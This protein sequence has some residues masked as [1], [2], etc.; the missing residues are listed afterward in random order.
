MGNPVLD[1]LERDEAYG[2]VQVLAEKPSGVTELVVP[3]GGGPLYVRKRIP[4]AIA[5]IEAWVRLSS[6][7]HPHLPHVIEMYQLPDQFVVVCAYVEG[8]SAARLVTSQGALETSQAL[9]IIKDVC[10]AAGVLHA[11]GI[12]HRDIT[13]TNV[14]VANDGAHLIDLGIARVED[15]S[16][17]HDTTRLGTWGFAAPEQFGFA[18]TDARSDVY[19]IGSFAAY[20]LTG[21]RPDE[22]GF[23]AAFDAL[24]KTVRTCIDKAR[25]FEPSARYGSAAELSL[26]FSEAATASR[27]VVKRALAKAFPAQGI[28]LA[29]AF[30]SAPT[31]RKLLAMILPLPILAMP[32]TGMN[33]V[34]ERWETLGFSSRIGTALFFIIYSA[35]WIGSA[36]N[37]ARAL[38][39]AGRYA[40]E[41]HRV[42]RFLL[43]ET[44][45][46]FA[47]IAL[48]VA[49]SYPFGLG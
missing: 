20:L 46:F 27:S 49:V 36:I 17:R 24:P 10:D 12:I 35:F 4:L 21:I 42:A 9:A 5:N 39:G 29:Q 14:I 28:S 11:Y 45:M 18:Q 47:M 43:N 6:I 1:A 8:F 15:A 33:T 2:V 34:L 22:Q 44:L 16:A 23:E 30:R 13:P 48:M 31:S 37:C 26:A 38:V 40:T 32:V 41:N 7:N 25:A 19:S 3:L